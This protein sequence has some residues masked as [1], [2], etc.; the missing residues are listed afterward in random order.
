MY[1]GHLGERERP[2]D[3]SRERENT[4]LSLYYMTWNRFRLQ[5]YRNGGQLWAVNVFSYT[6]HAQTDCWPSRFPLALPIFF[7]LLLWRFPSSQLFCVH[8]TVRTIYLGFAGGREVHTTRLCACSD[9]C[10]SWGSSMSR[11][12]RSDYKLGNQATGVWL[13]GQRQR[14]FPLSS[15]SRPTLRTTQPSVQWLPRSFPRR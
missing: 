3:D 5:K 1:S 13:P 14:I 12:I 10:Q 6:I 8:Y 2:Q 11:S 9:R 15:V 4:M 7:P